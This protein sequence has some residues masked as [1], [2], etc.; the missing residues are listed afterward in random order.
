MRRFLYLLGYDF[1]TFEVPLC[2]SILDPNLTMKDADDDDSEADLM[3]KVL[4]LS[5]LIIF[6]RK[7]FRDIS[8]SLT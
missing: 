6:Y 4:I 5:N 1:K 8:T 2:L 7:N 3:P